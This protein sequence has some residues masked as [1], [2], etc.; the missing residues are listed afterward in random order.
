MTNKRKFD[1]IVERIK[2][3]DWIIDP[4]Y[5]SIMVIID[6]LDKLEEAGIIECAFNMTPIGKNVAA[7][8][9][10]FDWQPTDK[11]IH[12]FAEAMV[13]EPERETIGYLL[14]QFRDDR[15]KLL[16]DNERTKS[17]EN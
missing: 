5:I 1:A 6:Y 14:K 13:E 4:S 8:C 12:R 7:I 9:E 17:G 10:E 2:A 3:E 16:D 11:D 15:E